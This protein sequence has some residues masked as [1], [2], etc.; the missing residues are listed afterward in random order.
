MR[1]VIVLIAVFAA[2][3]GHPAFA[4]EPA[5]QQPTRIEINQE[6][7]T[8]VFIIDDK[9]VALLDKNGPIVRE[10][11]VYGGTLT[12]AGTVLGSDSKRSTARCARRFLESTRT[13]S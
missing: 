8:F 4:D 13:A 2:L 10:G 6:A 7:K 12:D 11:I 1:I 9:P 3:T 5:N